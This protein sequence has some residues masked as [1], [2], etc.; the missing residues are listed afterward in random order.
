MERYAIITADN[1]FEVIHLSTS[2][3]GGAGI[4]ARRLNADLNSIGVKSS[5]YAIAQQD[6]TLGLN[7][8]SIERSFYRLVQAYLSTLVSK[9]T[10]NITFFSIFS[11]SSFSLKWLKSRIE[12]GNAVVHIHNWFN[13]TSLRQLRK[14]IEI[15]IPVVITLHDQRLITGGCHASLDCRQFENGCKKC[16][17]VSRLLHSRVRK[18]SKDL[19]KLF[20]NCYDNLKLT[21]PSKFMVTQASKSWVMSSQKVIFL[22]NPIPKYEQTQVLKAIDTG[23]NIFRIGVASANPDDPL[24]GGDLIYELEK[25]LKTKVNDIEIVYLANYSSEK[26][27]DFWISLDCL[28]VPSRGDNSPNV[29]HEAKQFGLPIIATEVGGITEMLFSDMDTLI[30]ISELTAESILSAINVVKGKKFD[31]KTIE[32]M[33]NAYLECV[34]EPL[35]KTLEIYQELLTAKSSTL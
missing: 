14:I 18:N 17:K 29:I 20:N 35:K 24:K 6:F 16:P 34:G 26:Y 12:T 22:P 27:F 2:H 8:Y 10:I 9:L 5:F 15:G 3:K 33:Q 31:A 19:H 1:N 13:L 21:T 32:R 7:E 25:I 4:A 11:S 30:D 23:K 28:L